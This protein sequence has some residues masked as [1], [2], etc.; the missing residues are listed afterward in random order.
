MTDIHTGKFF[1]KKPNLAPKLITR[2]KS[3]KSCFHFD[4]LLQLRQYQRWLEMV[5]CLLMLDVLDDNVKDGE[6]IMELVS[7]KASYLKERI[8][9]YSKGMI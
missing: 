8:D 5:Y 4:D 3:N 2:L 7:E 6:K 9:F 1:T